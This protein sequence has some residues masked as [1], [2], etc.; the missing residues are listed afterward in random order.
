MNGIL[1]ILCTD[2]VGLTLSLKLVVR[3]LLTLSTA[4]L[5]VDR[6]T[7]QTPVAHLTAANVVNED[8]KQMLEGPGCP[9]GVT[10]GEA[11]LS[12]AVKVTRVRGEP[13][14][15]IGM[16][17]ASKICLAWVRGRLTTCMI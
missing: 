11:L 9:Q 12:L 1:A 15:G 14:I 16:M 4:F 10:M 3:R 5:W 7:S 6:P 17:R 13:L 8:L 2:V